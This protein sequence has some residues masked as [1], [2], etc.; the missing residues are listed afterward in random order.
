MPDVADSLIQCST[1]DRVM[2]AIKRFDWWGFASTDPTG[3][4]QEMLLDD[5]HHR[6]LSHFGQEFDDCQSLRVSRNDNHYP[7]SG[8]NAHGSDNCADHRRD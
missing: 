8:G 6:N 3:W 2:N 7:K 5:T 1:L 4:F